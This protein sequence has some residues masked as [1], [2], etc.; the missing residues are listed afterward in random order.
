M[1]KIYIVP[2]FVTTAN[3][4]C[5]FY[6]VI[7]SMQGDFQT[8]AW[9]IM[10]AAVFDALDGRVARLAKAT[11]QFG[12]EYDSLSDLISFGMAPAILLYQWALQPF[13]RL[14]WLAAFLFMACG[15]L[16]L[17]RFNVSANLLPKAYFQGLPIPMGAGVVATFIIFHQTVGWPSM[18]A[19]IPRD[20]LALGLTFGLASLMVSTIR[21]PSFKEFNWRSRASF[22]YLMVG[23]LAMI[24]IAVKPEVTLFLLLSTYVGLS[25]LWNLFS[26]V[27]GSKPARLAA[28]SSHTQSGD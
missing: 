5:G 10:A 25:L 14:G 11:S 17:A 20:I 4:F 24:L 8:A 2:N 7:A 28:S 19:D 23:V 6:S 13:G 9:A 16:R 18:S 22:G 12:V 26:W 3:M 27:K 15:A 1:R 21:F